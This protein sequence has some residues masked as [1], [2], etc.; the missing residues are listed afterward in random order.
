M[1]CPSLPQPRPLHRVSVRFEEKKK[2]L[3]ELDCELNL[4]ELLHSAKAAKEKIKQISQTEEEKKKKK[5]IG[6]NGLGAI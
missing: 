6:R 4:T 5:K 3:A 1:P 2:K